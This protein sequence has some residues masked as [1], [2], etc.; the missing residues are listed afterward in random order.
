[1]AGPAMVFAQRGYAA[2]SILRRGFGR[3]DGPYAERIP[4]CDKPDYLGVGRAAAEDVGGAVA[5]LRREPWVD[6]KRVVLLGSSSGGFAV[7]AAGAAGP[8]G[9]VGILSFA[10]GQG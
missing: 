9:V 4:D 6:P 7:V 3:S 2:V 10:G 8:P 5:T 1:M